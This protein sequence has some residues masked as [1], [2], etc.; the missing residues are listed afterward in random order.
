MVFHG[1]E[2]VVGKKM[3]NKSKTISTSDGSNSKKETFQVMTKKRVALVFFK[4]IP[5]LQEGTALKGIDE[6][7]HIAE[8]ASNARNWFLKR[9]Y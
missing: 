2:A 4:E 5:R 7:K 9:Y 1:A 8:K 6:M 3:G